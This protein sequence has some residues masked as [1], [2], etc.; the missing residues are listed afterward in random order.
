MIKLIIK[1]PGLFLNI[2]GVFSCRTPVEIDITK[3][4]MS[5]ITAELKK[6]GIDKY[7]ILLDKEKNQEKIIEKIKS[8]KTILKTDEDT[9]FLN[10]DNELKKKQNEIL[11]LLKN[12][13][14]E[15][16]SDEVINTLKVQQKSINRL[17]L[18]LEK[19][20]NS[21]S[22]SIQKD[23]KSKKKFDDGK[24]DDFIPSINLDHIKIKGSSTSKNI[25]TK[26]D[27]SSA[28]TLSSITKK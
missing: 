12:Q 16:K 3:I 26:T 21:D 28:K 2:P 11:E 24:I 5:L 23:D 14:K 6:Q 19:F 4:N 25:S 9:V 1:K 20:L 13:Q 18:L 17:E 22:S 27:L 15:L 10:I 7:Q 8:K